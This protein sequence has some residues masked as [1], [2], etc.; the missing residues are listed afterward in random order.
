MTVDFSWLVPL[1]ILICSPTR[2]NSWESVSQWRWCHVCYQDEKT[3]F[4]SQI[5]V[6][7][8]RMQLIKRVESD[9]RTISRLI[10]SLC[11]MKKAILFKMKGSRKLSLE[12]INCKKKQTSQVKH[13]IKMQ[14][15]SRW[16][17]HE[18]GHLNQGK[19]T[20]KQP[21]IRRQ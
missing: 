20:T 17:E 9:A 21:L 12:E 14:L 4:N 1:P 5:S 6:Y 8:R 15:Y 7:M 11:S 13:T 3:S 18:N 19:L 16:I 10:H 2:K